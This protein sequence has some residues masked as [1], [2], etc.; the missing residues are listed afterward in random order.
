MDIFFYDSR[1]SYVSPPRK[2][3]QPFV[4]KTTHTTNYL[5]ANKAVRPTLFVSNA[6]ILP[7]KYH[8]RVKVLSVF[9]PLFVKLIM[10]CT[11]TKLLNMTSVG[12]TINISLGRN[13]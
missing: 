5:R 9:T 4:K 7:N 11:L 13:I 12:L 1:Y 8:T 2:R 10:V 3:D 6:V